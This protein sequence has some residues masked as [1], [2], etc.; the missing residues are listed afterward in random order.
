MTP[1]E[2]LFLVKTV[3]LFK[4]M[5]DDVLQKL[6]PALEELHFA[7]GEM[8]VKK[9][10]FGIE[11]YVIASGKV[12]VH[13]G[14]KF[15]TELEA[16]DVFG[17]LAALMPETRIASVSAVEDS[18]L[19]KVSHD[20]LYDIMSK[21][22]QLAKGIIEVLCMRT[23][24]ISKLQN[25][26]IQQEKLVS[27]GLLSSGIAHEIKNPLNLMIN[28]SEV[29]CELIEELI[30]ELSGNKTKIEPQELKERLLYLND[31]LQKIK[32]HGKKADEIVKGL[33]NHAHQ[34]RG[35]P[36][37]TELKALLDQ[38]LSLIA[39]VFSKKDPRF[40]A[41]VITRYDPQAM[42]IEVFANDLVRVFINIIDNAYYE[43]HEKQISDSQYEPRL[44]IDL[45]DH[46]KEVE[47]V[48]KDNGNGIL[49]ENL[50]KI[51]QPFFTTKPQGKGAGLGLSLS[52]DI[53]TQQHGGKLTVS[54][55]HATYAKFTILLPKK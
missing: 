48:I 20:T 13:D 41:Q 15:L 42:P 55:D 51:F 54:S 44:E 3:P 23:R 5:S 37:K 27:L 12:K 8:I 38:A 7:S 36:E 31:F 28:L 2:K 17:E 10:E 45:I 32:T 4:Y 1:S 33:L 14:D 30:S 43:M 35:K 18:V 26:L 25:Q 39:Q 47:I 22:I 24:S 11:M 9:G 40:K 21:N 19:L 34:S 6:V 50:D 16:H 29:S 53:V 46:P 49:Q 52:Y